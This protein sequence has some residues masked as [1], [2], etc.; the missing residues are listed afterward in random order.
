M[1]PMSGND[2]KHASEGECN[3]CDD[4]PRNWHLE[5]WDLSGDEPDTSKQ[6]QQES[7][8][9]ERDACVMA[10]RKHG[11]D[12]SCCSNSEIGGRRSMT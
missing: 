6:D 9:G 8:L 11:K 3:A 7:N 1:T 2:E 10:Q 12:G 4:R 5:G